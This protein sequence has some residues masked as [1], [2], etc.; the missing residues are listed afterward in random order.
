RV[1]DRWLAKDPGDRFETAS[2]TREALEDCL[3]PSRATIYDSVTSY[4][5][6]SAHTPI[7]GSATPMPMRAP[8]PPIFDSHLIDRPKRRLWPWVVFLLAVAGGGALG[9]VLLYDNV[10]GRPPHPVRS[11]RARPGTAGTR[12]AARRAPAGSPAGAKAGTTKPSDPRAADTKAAD[13]KAADTM[14]ADAKAA[15]T[16]PPDTKPVDAKPADAKAASGAKA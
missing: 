11:A 16:K 6:I 7:P 15:D 12:R 3:D 14:A 2:E 9:Y 8:T 1:V 10:G 13:T 5:A 4:P